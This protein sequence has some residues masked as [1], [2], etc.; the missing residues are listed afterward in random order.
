[1]VRR[2]AKNL[3]AGLLLYRRKGNEIEVLLGHHG[4]P[5]WARKDIGS[6][7]IPKG[8]VAEGEPPLLAAR[9]EFQEE[10]GYNPDGNRIALG[11]S[12]QPGGKLVVVFAVEGD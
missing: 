2:A 10:T 1:V 7:T 4:G 9:R 11:E 3:S 12:R 5:F 8:L 6:W